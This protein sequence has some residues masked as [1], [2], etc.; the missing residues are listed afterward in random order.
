MLHWII[1]HYQVKTDNRS[2]I[3]NDPNRADEPVYIVNLI[4]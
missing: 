1:D 4:Q 2:G 3:A